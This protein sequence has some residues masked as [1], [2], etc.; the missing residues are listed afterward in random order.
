[1]K[2]LPPFEER[3]FAEQVVAAIVVP[4]VFGII[5]GLALGWNGIVYWI[6]IGPLAVAGG[7]L[8]GLDHRGADDGFIRGLISGLVYGSFTLIGFEIANT[9]AKAYLGEPQAG[10][11]FVTTFV[12]AI[13]G[14]LGGWYRPRLERR[15]P[16]AG[17][18]PAG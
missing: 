18:A 6:L 9:D 12:G 2:L 3:S 1:M 17:R 13:L 14:A 4:M 7:F 16:P 10:L 8:G 5:T 15:P 11:V